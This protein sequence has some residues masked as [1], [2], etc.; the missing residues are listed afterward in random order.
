MVPTVPMPLEFEAMS[1]D[2][3]HD[4]INRILYSNSGKLTDE[5][6]ERLVMLIVVS[7]KKISVRNIERFIA[8]PNSNNLFRA[9][10]S[11]TK[12]RKT[13]SRALMF[14]LLIRRK[15]WVRYVFNS[16]KE[17]SKLLRTANKIIKEQ[18]MKARTF[19]RFSKNTV[20]HGAFQLL[21]EFFILRLADILLD[22]ELRKLEKEYEIE[23]FPDEEDEFTADQDDED[24]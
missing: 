17:I 12:V 8:E 6:I 10:E 15:D 3:L 13:F 23:W 21:F 9:R 4:E 5:D 7:I 18:K 22:S 1:L 19:P 14:F 11:F 16:T 2:E 20:H 24:L